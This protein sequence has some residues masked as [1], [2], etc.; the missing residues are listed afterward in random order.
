MSLAAV[1]RFVL[2]LLLASPQAWRC[3]QGPVVPAQMMRV[4]ATAVALEKRCGHR[5]PTSEE[6]GARR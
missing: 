5:P 1:Q 3:W 4:V 6:T 2:Q